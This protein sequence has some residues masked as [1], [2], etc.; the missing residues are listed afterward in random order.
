MFINNSKIVKYYT[1]LQYFVNFI[2]YEKKMQILIF[3][4][5]VMFLK[6]FKIPKKKTDFVKN[7]LCVKI[8]HVRKM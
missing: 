7:W 8:Y 5:N 2:M 3:G 6:L 4:G 1:N